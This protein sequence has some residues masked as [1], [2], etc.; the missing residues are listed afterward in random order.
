MRPWRSVKHPH[1]YEINTRVLLTSLSEPGRRATLDDVPD[2]YWQS[3]ADR[4]MHWVWLM[5]VWTLV[6][7]QHDPDLIPA[8]MM[9]EFRALLPDLSDADIDGSPYAID[10]YEVDPR[11]GGEEAL[12]RVRQTLNR[13]GI[14]LMLDFVP[15]HF[16]A[17]TRWLSTHPE[18]FLAVP[19][20]AARDGSN[21]FFSPKGMDSRYFAHGKDPYFAAW[22]DTLQVDYSKAETR[23]FMSGQLERLATL[24]DGVRC[25]MAMLAVPR[26]FSQTWE[27]HRIW[28]NTPFWPRAIRQ[29]K[30][31]NPDFTLLAEVYWDMES[32]MLAM[33][34]DYCYDKTFYDRLT[35]PQGLK[36]HFNAEPTYL[37]QTA[38]FLENHDEQRV[39]ARLSFDQH[40][41]AAALVG[42]GPGMRFW[43][44]GQ[45]EGLK[46]KIPVQLNRGPV[47]HCDCEVCTRDPLP[48]GCRQVK[49]MYDALFEV[50]NSDVLIDGEWSHVDHPDLWVWEWRLEQEWRLVAMNYSNAPRSMPEMVERDD[51]SLIYPEAHITSSVKE[52]APWEVR[53]WARVS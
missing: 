23:A 43:H 32:E 1:L 38:R 50:F 8:G 14:G 53:V 22:Q 6:E 46:R 51:L 11:L 47:E 4:G 7:K 30:Q 18:Y 5:G 2:I 49:Q 35:E 37:T 25:D 20:A 15:N 28:N 44:M 52:L 36:A 24:C 17:H 9:E 29:A 33:G 41:A 16:G 19:A 39:A 31:V 10:A 12:L 34:F 40:A 42:F 26:V 21:T 13:L 27:G 48:H 45:W 3:L